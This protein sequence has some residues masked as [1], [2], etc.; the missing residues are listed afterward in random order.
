MA[1]WSGLCHR[2]KTTATEGTS[3]WPP[4]LGTC[5]E[6]DWKKQIW[7][8]TFKVETLSE[9]GGDGVLW[10]G[11]VTP[12]RGLIQPPHLCLYQRQ[13]HRAAPLVREHLLCH[14]FRAQWSLRPQC[15]HSPRHR[16]RQPLKCPCPGK[17]MPLQCH[18]GW[19]VQACHLEAP[20]LFPKPL[21][22]QT[23]LSPYIRD[24]DKSCAP[25]PN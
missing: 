5:R 1:L 9:V 17:D 2:S 8:P 13:W 16:G 25:P 4:L 15:S 19:R 24:G 14:L 23:S 10:P 18:S 3:P 20:S 11:A 21:R 7:V 12:R 22:L 6:V